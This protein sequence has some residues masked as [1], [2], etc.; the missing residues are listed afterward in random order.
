M[1]VQLDVGHLFC[2]EGFSK[3]HMVTCKHGLPGLL[4]LLVPGRDATCILRS[5]STLVADPPGYS[6]IPLRLLGPW[7]D[8]WPGLCLYLVQRGWERKWKLNLRVGGQ[9]GC[10]WPWSWPW[11]AGTVL[12]H[13]GAASWE[14]G[15]LESWR[16][17]LH[18]RHVN[19]N[20]H[21]A[22]AAHMSTEGS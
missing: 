13:S 21:L 14:P 5:N 18:T 7:M 15:F 8:L 16:E 3:V 12:W 22:P 4:I 10:P 6:L 9:R 1:W 2:C 20:P 19:A 17:K 11:A